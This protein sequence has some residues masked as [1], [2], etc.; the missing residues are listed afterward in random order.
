MRTQTT[1]DEPTP[2]PRTVDPNWPMGPDVL[3]LFAIVRAEVAKTL[4]LIGQPTSD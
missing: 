4:A 3:D 1:S 2:T